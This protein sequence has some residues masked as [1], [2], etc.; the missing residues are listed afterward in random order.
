MKNDA[1][2]LF[3]LILL[4]L[5]GVISFSSLTDGHHWGGDFSQY[6]M[7]ARSI[8][9]GAPAKVIEENRIML[10]ES[11]SPPFCPLAYPWGLPVLLAPF[12][13]V[14]GADILIL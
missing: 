1:A 3:F 7:Q 11:S 9:E 6:I 8:L 2:S 10:Q 14:F 12:Y 13:A 5:I 4:C